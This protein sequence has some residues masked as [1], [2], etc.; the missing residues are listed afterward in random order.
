MKTSRF[1]RRVR[2]RFCSDSQDNDFGFIFYASATWGPHGLTFPFSPGLGGKVWD[3]KAEK[4]LVIRREKWKDAP[5][6]EQARLFAFARETVVHM[7][8]YAVNRVELR[9]DAALCSAWA[10]EFLVLSALTTIKVAADRAAAAAARAQVRNR[11][12]NVLC[13]ACRRSQALRT[14]RNK[15]INAPSVSHQH[16]RLLVAIEVYRVFA[17]CVTFA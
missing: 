10:V 2:F 7:A 13:A 3:D 8:D 15:I 11:A 14:H 9:I 4:A 12:G 1:E 6:E 16:R 17:L 5:R